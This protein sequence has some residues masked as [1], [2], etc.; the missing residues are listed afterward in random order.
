MLAVS[1]PAVKNDRVATAPEIAQQ[2]E[3]YLAPMEA[4]RR[5]RMAIEDMAAVGFPLVVSREVPPA[6]WRALGARP[7]AEYVLPVT[8]FSLEARDGNQGMAGSAL[9]RGN[10]LRLAQAVELGRKW[11]PKEWPA[12][13]ATDLNGAKHL[14]TVN[15]L[16]WLKPWR[17]LVGVQRG[18]K[19]RPDLPDFDWELKFREGTTDYTIN[20]EVKR[21]TSNLNAWFKHGTS[22]VSSR[23]I[24]HKFAPSEDSTANFAALTTFQ[25]PD[26]AARR[27]LVDWLRQHDEVD[28]VVIW[29]EHSAGTEPLVGIV[30]PGKQWAARLVAPADPED[31][32]IASYA[33]G[34]LCLEHEVPAFLDRLAER[35]SG[36]VS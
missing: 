9:T 10:L 11:L 31:L 21:R 24:S 35:H 19:A 26:D 34:T 3:Y 33:W 17:G 32:M 2:L 4:A 29:V 18:P 6:Q 28:G 20:L 5:A 15:E 8:P 12:T 1:A 22:P 36:N 23:D 14:D 13:F 30:K 7:Q 16:W 25:P 27:N